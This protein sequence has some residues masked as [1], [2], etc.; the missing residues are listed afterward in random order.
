MDWTNEGDDITAEEWLEYVRSDPDFRLDPRNG[1]C[2]AEGTEESPISVV[3]VT[4]V[5]SG[6]VGYWET[7]HRNR[8]K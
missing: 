4:V 5:I 6:V 7:V 2:H 8:G 1:P 3:V